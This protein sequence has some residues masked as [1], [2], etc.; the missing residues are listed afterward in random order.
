MSCSQSVSLGA[1]VLG[2][3]EPAERAAFEAHLSGC[4]SCQAELVR[5]APLPGLLHQLSEEDFTEEPEEHAV[6]QSDP[7]AP[8][9]P[10][11]PVPAHVVGLP[12]A[13]PPRQRGRSAWLVAAAVLLVLVGVGAFVVHEMTSEQPAAPVAAAPVTWSATDPTTGIRADIDLIEKP[14]GTELQ[15][16]LRDVPPGQTCKLTVRART[17]GREVAGWWATRYGEVEKI[18][19]STSF[20]AGDIERL[21]IVNSQNALLVGI[22]RPR[23]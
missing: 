21:E 4:T 12:P 11:L 13:K 19:G 7:S 15:M 22:D 8:I 23:R 3:L 16:R 18:P 14:W 9:E 2:A 20:A 10:P 1:Y 5:L 6:E 17:G